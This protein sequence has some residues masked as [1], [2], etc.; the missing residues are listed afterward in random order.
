[1]T[2]RYEPSSTKRFLERGGVEH[3]GIDALRLRV[4]EVQVPDARC[5]ACDSPATTRTPVRA[6]RGLMTF[7]R[8]YV[9][10]AIPSCGRHRALR[11]LAIAAEY[12]AV[13]VGATAL[14]AAAY[15]A[16]VAATGAAAIDSEQAVLSVLVGI[17]AGV[18]ACVLGAR[19]PLGSAGTWAALGI[20]ADDPSVDLLQVT[21]RVRSNALRERLAARAKA[22]DGAP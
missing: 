1:M 12:L 13:F 20:R 9:E 11:Q 15:L 17:C 22:R 7:P 6:W 18:S 3:V 5:I 2:D 8:Q 10:L 16:Y 14:T 19:L 4:A 21:V